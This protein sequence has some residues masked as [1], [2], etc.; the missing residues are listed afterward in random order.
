MISRFKIN[1]LLITFI[2][3]FIPTTVIAASKHAL[4]IGIQDYSNTSFN[5][6]KGPVNDIKLTADMLRKRFGFSQKNFIIL[7]NNKATH[8]GIEKAFKTLIKRVNSNDFVYIHYSGHGSQTADLNGDEKKDQTWVSYGARSSNK[9]H[10]NNYDV[11]DDEINA[12]LAQL[13]D[14]TEQVVFVSDSC[15][16][17]TVSRGFDLT[18]AIDDDDRS[19]ILG[20]LTYTRPA[21]ERGIRVG[22]ARDHESAVDFPRKNGQYY[23][24]FTWHW[25]KN[26]QQAQAGDTW[27]HIYKRTYA[28]VTAKRGVVQQPQMA[29]KRSQQVLGGGFTPQ[30]PTIPVTRINNNWIKIPAGSLSS[31]TIG[32]VYRLYKPQHPNPQRLPRLTITQVKPFASYGKPKGTFQ[33]GDLVTEENHAYHFTPIKVSLEADFPNGKDKSFLQAIKTAFDMKRFPAYRLTNNPSNAELR[34]HLLRPKRKNGSPIRR[35]KNDLLPKS[36]S[37]QAAELW[38]L[39]SEQR[40][41]YENLQMRFANLTKG[42][43]LLQ[44]NLNKLARIRELKTLQSH[45]G[46][47]K[48]PVTL[49]SYILRPDNSC[50]SKRNCLKLPNGLGWHR[51][52][53][54]YALSEIETRTLNK[55]DILTFSLHNRSRRRAYYCY[56]FNISPN[57]AISSIFPEPEDMMEYAR[58]NARERL[59]LI[60]ETGLMVEKGQETVKFIISRYPIDVSLL[61][62]EAFEQRGGNFNLSELLLFAHTVYGNRGRVSLRNDEWATGLATFDV[63]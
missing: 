32:S 13:Y 33:T 5:S 34:L 30:P 11:L 46:S 41:L 2:C 20:K 31:V 7:L 36:F 55:D 44:D 52:K 62:Q 28:Q 8:T 38:V 61:E 1:L 37:N 6:L 42:I 4:L 29:G 3:H 56:I 63:R 40:L 15:H 47:R 14:K 18:R 9:A 16:S 57:G 12:W 45:R 35:A 22:A 10:K 21:I 54:P 39:T 60:G 43:D 25:V 17:A 27:N 26:L 49:Q 50:R 48:L 58:V 51:K 59:D 24:M 53:G 23:G 19:H